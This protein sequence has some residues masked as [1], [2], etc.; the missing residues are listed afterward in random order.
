LSNAVY[1]KG[2]DLGNPIE[3]QIF[4]DCITVLSY[5]GAVPPVGQQILKNQKIVARNYRN[6]RIGDFLK[7]LD[8]TEGRGT[9][10]PKMF[11]KME[12][13]GSPLPII[14]TDEE[15]SYFMVTLPI[16]PEYVE[17]T[18]DKDSDKTGD[19]VNNRVNN[20][21]FKSLNDLVAFSNGV[22]NAVSN[23]VNNAAKQIII[24]EIHDKVKDILKTLIVPQKRSD[25]FKS[26]ALSNQSKNRAKYLDRLIDLGWIAKEFPDEINN[27]TQRYFTTESGKRILS[28]INV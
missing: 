4:M 22:N 16:N 12:N 21:I 17:A 7:E 25:L 6:R 8:L 24:E 3:V 28:L 9:G 5:P 13:N 2:Y 26:I 27:P 23:G 20:F 18:D 15:S 11:R 19:I 14:E 1:H 10:F